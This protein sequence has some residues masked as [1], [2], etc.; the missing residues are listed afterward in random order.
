M[1][2]MA[3]DLLTEIRAF[4]NRSG[5]GR[6]YFGKASCGNSEL[7]DRLESGGTV[8]LV[9]AEKIRAFIAERTAAQTSGAAA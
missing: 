9:T 5:M 6:S 1:G 4:L 3:N 8:T 7:V 2:D